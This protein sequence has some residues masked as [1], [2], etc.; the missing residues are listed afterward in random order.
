[1]FKKFESL[2]VSGMILS[3]CVMVV[4]FGLIFLPYNPLNLYSVEVLPDSVCS[5][6][7]VEVIVD[8]EVSGR[9]AATVHRVEL[10]SN[11]VAVD[12]EGIP[13][14]TK[15]L[16]AEAII[17]A[18]GL[19]E[20]AAGTGEPGEALRVAPERPGEWL[21]ETEVKLYGTRYWLP[22]LQEKKVMSEKET[23]VLPQD[24]PE[25]QKERNG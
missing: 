4:S 17:E 23:L 21:L 15:R 18:E 3:V 10:R 11:W 13:D 24:N 5:N 14:G 19:Q 20:Q 16:G 2:V 25:C 9:D 8:Y 6:A 7:D 12:V 1:M 22:V